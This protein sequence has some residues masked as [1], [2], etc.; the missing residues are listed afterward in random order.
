MPW[1]GA[2]LMVSRAGTV[3]QDGRIADEATEKKLRDFITGFAA[4]AAEHRR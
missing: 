3:I 4:F 1:F 2:K